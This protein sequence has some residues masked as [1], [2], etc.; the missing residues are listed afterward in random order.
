MSIVLVGF[1]GAGKSTVGPMVA[2]ELGF[3]FLDIDSAIEKTFSLPIT[4]IFTR[5]GEG[6]FRDQEAQAIRAHV[7]G[8]DT[9]IA[10]GA[11]AIENPGTRALLATEVVVLL[12]V[13]L[14]DALSRI[15]P[16]STRPLA[17]RPDI[18]EIYRRRIALYDEVAVFSVN[19]TNRQPKEIVS[20][21]VTK[22]RHC[23]TK[24]VPEQSTPDSARSAHKVR[25][26]QL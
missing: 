13:E 10:L 20:E 3:A 25:P 4:E 26:H 9:V 17:M 19:T 8:A 21:I 6:R 18:D 12:K 24:S 1:M 15:A 22:I 5:F 11:G 23:D 14:E 7:R 2:K 16:F